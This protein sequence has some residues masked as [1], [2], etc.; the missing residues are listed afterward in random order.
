[1]LPAEALEAL[2]CRALTRDET[3]AIFRRLASGGMDD[4]QAAALL[5]AL[6]T[7]GE[8][9]EGIRG[10][11]GAM[12]EAARPFPRPQYRFADCCGTGGDRAG[13]V[14]VSTAVAFVAAAAGLPIA[15]HGNHAV[16]SRC[17]SADLLQALGAEIE[18]PPET[19]RRAL[20]ECG[21]CYLHAPQY[22]P[23]ARRVA[24]VRRALGTRTLFNLLGPLLNPSR[25]P[26]RLV[27]VYAAELVLP[28]AQALARLGCEAGL[29]VHGGGLDE[30]ALHAPTTAARV[31]A[32]EVVELT[33]TPGEAGVASAPIEA[34]RGGGPGENA[35]WLRDLLAG[36]GEPAPVDAVAVN[37]GALLWIAGRAA[38]LREGTAQARAILREGRATARL[39]SYLEMTRRA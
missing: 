24:T 23:A 14:N 31:T 34:L 27:G 7:R 38:G 25:P 15:K 29:V 5:A 36:R 1:M 33:L 37:A 10:A 8:T 26:I 21:V 18:I 11:A 3:A 35:R 39:D 22:H 19:A 32:D 28:T 9:A 16:S 6:K 20:D 4:I 13:T 2:A 17:G 12:L 30:I